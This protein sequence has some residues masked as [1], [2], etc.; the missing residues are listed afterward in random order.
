MLFAILV[1]MAPSASFVCRIIVFYLGTGHHLSILLASVSTTARLG[2]VY[3]SLQQSYL[4]SSLQL[5]LPQRAS[6]LLVMPPKFTL[7]LAAADRSCEA[8]HGSLSAALHLDAPSSRW[9]PKAQH[10]L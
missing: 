1:A 7:A 6:V 4:I 9:D 5:L 10:Q 3:R 8:V 2:L